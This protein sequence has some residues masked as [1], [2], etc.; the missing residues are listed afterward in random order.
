MF[1]ISRDPY[2]NP[3]VA[4]LVTS[5]VGEETGTEK[6]SAFLSVSHLISVPRPQSYHPTRLPGDAVIQGLVFISQ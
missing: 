2:Y 5:I 1:I 3:E 6:L 4:A